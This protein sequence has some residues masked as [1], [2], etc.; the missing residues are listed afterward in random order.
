MPAFGLSAVPLPMNIRRTLPGCHPP[1]AAADDAAVGPAGSAL[2]IAA[3]ALVVFDALS[4]RRD[5]A[6]AAHANGPAS[7]ASPPE[8]VCSHDNS[9]A[10]IAVAEP[11]ARTVAAGATTGL[12]AA[13]A[14]PTA[15]T[16]IGAEFSAAA[17]APDDNTGVGTSTARVTG[18]ATDGTTD[19]TVGLR[20]PVTAAGADVWPGERGDDDA[21]GSDETALGAEPR[22]V[23]RDGTAT[24]VDGES[25][26]STD[27]EP[28]DPAEPVVSANANGIDAAAD[29]IPSATANAPTR[30]T[31]RP[32]P[33]TACSSA[34]TDRRRYSIARMRHAAMR[35]CRPLRSAGR[36]PPD[37]DTNSGTE[38]PNNPPQS[39]A[40]S[41]LANR[42]RS[43]SG[44][45][46][47]A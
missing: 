45:R 3:A 1:T 33:G 13:I 36:S 38:D 17:D 5:A 19:G 15:G 6:R 44:I 28:V 42:R 20:C 26:A 25:C 18:A 11:A 24:L 22:P 46:E 32:Y 27:P 21:S 4:S 34:G 8:P 47:I 7:G 2:L 31:C 41:P 30:P 16:A 12:G 43:A 37:S 35:R 29:P 9:V 40:S 14:D 10:P 39:M 23:R